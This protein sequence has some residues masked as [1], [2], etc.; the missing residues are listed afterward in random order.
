MNLFLAVLKTKFAKAQTIFHAKNAASNAKSRRNS[1][2]MFFSA[3]KT[4]VSD[5]SEDAD[6]DVCVRSGAHD[7]AALGV[8]VS[9]GLQ[10]L[11]GFII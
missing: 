4:K 11:C 1:L 6:A 5:V 8:A 10:V 3:V 7:R 2:V 9:P